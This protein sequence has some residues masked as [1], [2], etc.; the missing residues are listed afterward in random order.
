MHFFSSVALSAL[1]A[2]AS[3]AAVPETHVV[4]ERRDGLG[5][6][7][8]TKRDRASGVLPMR[9]GLTQ[10]NL[11]NAH[12][13]LMDISH[14]HSPN[15]GKHWTSDEVIDMFKPSDETVETVKNWLSDHGITGHVQSENKGW[16]AFHATVEQ[17]E[18]LL[19]TEYFEYEDSHTGGVL[20]ATEQ[21]HVPK[22]VQDHVD[23]ITPGIK[24]L[25]PSNEDSHAGKHHR[26]STP[27]MDEVH[28][29]R[30]YSHRYVK[31]NQLDVLNPEN[32][33]GNLS[34][35]DT[36]ITPACIAALYGIPDA[37]LS[38]PNNSM[39]IFEAEL[40]MW[41][42]EDLNLFFSNYSH[43]GIPNDTHPINNLVNGGIANTS[44]AFQAGPE[45]ELDL[46]V[47][48]PIVYPQT[49]TIFN[50][51]DRHYQLWA[52]NTYTW[53]FN[54]LLDA[55]DGSYCNYTAYGETGNA[56]GI[57]PTYPDKNQLGTMGYNGT[58]MCGTF[59]PTNVMSVSYGGQEADLPIAY[60]KRQCNE[61]MKLGLQGVSFVYASGDAGVG[62]YN[63]TVSPSSSPKTGCLGPKGNIFNPTWPNTCPYITNVGATKLHPGQ[64]VSD[65]E[66]AAFDPAGGRYPHAF[67][68]G[69]GFSNVY[70]IPDY[71]KDAV[72]H[73]FDNHEPSYPYYSGIVDN[74]TNPTKPNITALAGTSGGIY[75]RI[76]RGVPDV[77]A[78]G[79]NIAVFASGG[80]SLTAGTSASAPIFGAI[81]NRINEERLAANKSTVGFVNPVLYTFP[82]V[83]NDVVNGTN[84]GCGTEGFQAVEGWDPV[85]GLGTPDFG[86]M[87]D[88]WMGLP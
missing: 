79:D 62:N 48:Y 77:A 14:P 35:C 16:M 5:D 59:K 88:L 13:H 85:T 76:G 82:S 34:T 18:S 31:L 81:L 66:S 46:E 19:H 50:V 37:N 25:A 65:R 58:L 3:G 41:Y 9:I 22:H 33:S 12:E 68:S 7:R 30:P 28:Q 21:Y 4:H 54:T 43:V 52:N 6:G 49:I 51:D 64:N 47:A 20:P 2:L 24:L 11:G 73:F 72:A 53:G 10:Q 70:P 71:Q 87:M 74:A 32:A 67:A 80:F 78:V 17:A 23:Y 26:R 63:D 60:Q 57:D 84:P 27:S 45:A 36:T 1:V 56:E 69:G 86:K 75:N 40:Q 44:Y 38:H 39:G 55:I 8:W 29:Q 42:Q 61:F 15:Y 83:L